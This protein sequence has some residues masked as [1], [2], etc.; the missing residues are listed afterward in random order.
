MMLE[1]VK[2]LQQSRS[3]QNKY[4]NSPLIV[5]RASYAQCL[6]PCWRITH[7]EWLL[8]QACNARA[9]SWLEPLIVIRSIVLRDPEMNT[10][11][12]CIWRHI[13]FASPVVPQSGGAWCPLEPDLNVHVVLIKLA[14]VVENDIALRLVQTHNA[15][16]HGAVNEQ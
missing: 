5:V 12:L 13:G 9:V 3:F 2:L 1:S 11:S 7:E 6:P 4:G 8:R 10:V 15:H 14:E 16:G